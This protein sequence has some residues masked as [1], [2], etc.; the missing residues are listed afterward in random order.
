MSSLCVCGGGDAS[1]L[2]VVG[3]NIGCF[4]CEDLRK[5]LPRP[6]YEETQMKLAKGVVG[7]GRA[8]VERGN[9]RKSGGGVRG[10]GG[11]GPP[12][13][14]VTKKRSCTPPSS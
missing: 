7:W 6:Q 9:E 3:V 11:W 5:M 14:T 8:G 4:T 12:V 2:I 13:A 10:S 1:L